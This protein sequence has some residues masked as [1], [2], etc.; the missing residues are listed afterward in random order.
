VSHE[1][2]HD[3]S[4]ECGEPGHH[5]FPGL[6]THDVLTPPAAPLP[7]PPAQVLELAEACV[8]FVATM[9]S[10]LSGKPSP[11]LAPDYTPETLS[12]VDHY[13]VES[14]RA[15]ADRPEALPLTAHAVGAYLGEVVRRQH[16]AWWRTE[17]EDPTAWRLEFESA[18][19]SFYPLELAY[20][21]LANDDGED[22]P[23]SGF[24]LCDQDREVLATRLAELPPVSEEEYLLPSTRLEVLDIALETVVAK[25]VDDP[26][27]KRAYAPSDYEG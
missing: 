13:V 12:L 3:C 25:Q 5:P 1:H 20:T 17:G 7:E 19:M 6:A 24:E 10:T 9:M 21:L 15:L 18:M 27:A 14:R 8:K 16:R 2:D 22:E 11:D 26:D 4:D 23:W